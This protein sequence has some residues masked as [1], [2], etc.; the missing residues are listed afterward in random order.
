MGEI[1]QV[2]HDAILHCINGRDY[3]SAF[4]LLRTCVDAAP[5]AQQHPIA[6]T[7]PENPRK[8]AAFARG[9]GTELTI[10]P[11]P[12]FKAWAALGKFWLTVEELYSKMVELKI[13]MPDEATAKKAIKRK[14]QKRSGDFRHTPDGLQWNYL[15]LNKH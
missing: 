13:P 1:S 8:R 3:N 14:M 6:N 15:P 5:I 10:D 4:A 11:V 7:A 2:C 12:A 9:A